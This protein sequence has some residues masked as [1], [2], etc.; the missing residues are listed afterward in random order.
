[1]PFIKNDPN[2]NRKGRPKGPSIKEWIQIYLKK[3]PDKFED[4][5]KFYLEDSKMKD[6]LWKMLEGLPKQSLEHTGAEGEAIQINI[7]N[8]KDASKPKAHI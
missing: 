4:L 7:I 1:M 5:C 6:L 8:F 3:N 2:I